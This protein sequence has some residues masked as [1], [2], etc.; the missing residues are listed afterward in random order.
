MKRNPKGL[1]YAKRVADVTGLYER[2]AHTGLSNREI[3]R[4]Y[5]WPRYGVSERTLY[6]MLGAPAHKTVGKLDGQG[7]LFPE[8]LEEPGA[9]AAGTAAAES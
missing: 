8:L 6:N 2:Y 7:F 3:W 1:S 5:I 9:D 4:R